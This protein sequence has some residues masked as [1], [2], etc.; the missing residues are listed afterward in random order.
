MMTTSM[1]KQGKKWVRKGVFG[2]IYIVQSMIK[3][4]INKEPDSS[5]KG[6]LR[7][8]PKESVSN[9][10][11]VKQQRSGLFIININKNQIS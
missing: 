9:K 5:S 1:T 11:V 8:F 3:K 4:T 2:K 10:I 7:K 6:D